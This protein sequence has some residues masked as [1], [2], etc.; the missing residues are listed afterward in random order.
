M[1]SFLA[2]YH[3][4]TNEYST[5]NI[6]V[7]YKLY[8][9][10]YISILIACKSVHYIHEVLLETRED[11]ESLR[12]G[13]MKDYKLSWECWKLDLSPLEEQQRSQ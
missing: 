5:S 12:F 9:F 4:L 6:K 8:L 13:V 7:F 2:I 11:V 3:F 10:I 1:D